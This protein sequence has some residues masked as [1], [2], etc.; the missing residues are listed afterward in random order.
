MGHSSLFYLTF[1]L[2]AEFSFPLSLLQCWCYASHPCDLYQGLLSS[3][4]HLTLCWV[5]LQGVQPSAV[6][7]SAC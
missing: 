4:V 6:C 5:R 2:S 7:G 1:L 3:Q